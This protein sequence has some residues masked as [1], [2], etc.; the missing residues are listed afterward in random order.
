MNE[1][2]EHLWRDGNQ[3][4]GREQPCQGASCGNVLGV[5]QHLRRHKKPG[6]QS[7]NH[8]R[9]SSMSASRSSSALKGRTTEPRLT[10]GMSRTPCDCD[11]VVGGA[12]TV[13]SC[14]S[15]R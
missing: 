14:P 1:F 12:S 2:S 10:G 4:A 15:G 5:L 8:E 3:V 7:M 6:V 9:P 13:T 11:P